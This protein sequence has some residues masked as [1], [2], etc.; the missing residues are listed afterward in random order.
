MTLT[1]GIACGY[2]I[3]VSQDSFSAAAA[4][5]EIEQAGN[6]SDGERAGEGFQFIKL[7]GEITAADQRAYRSSGDHADFDALFVKRPEH[8]DMRPSTGGAA[9]KRDGDLW[10]LWRH[11]GF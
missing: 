2:A 7:A 11:G 5:G 9:A 3:A 1:C 8:A 10:W 4:D 6:A